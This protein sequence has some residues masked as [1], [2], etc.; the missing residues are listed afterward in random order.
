MTRRR[1][2]RVVEVDEDRVE[3]APADRLDDG[4]RR[5]GGFD[6]VP[7]ALEKEPEGF[8]DVGLVVGYQDSR[9]HRSGLTAVVMGYEL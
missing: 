6:L 5:A 2:A 7:L 1:V 9:K 4:R 3:L 8:D